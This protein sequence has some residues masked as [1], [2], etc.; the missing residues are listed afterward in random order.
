MLNDTAV[1]IGKK[2]HMIFLFKKLFKLSH[3]KP[4]ELL[5]FK[6]KTLQEIEGC[7]FKSPKARELLSHPFSTHVS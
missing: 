2:G 3:K 6:S 4:Y 5:Y 1:K 7:I